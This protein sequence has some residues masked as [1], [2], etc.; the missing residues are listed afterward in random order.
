MVALTEIKGERLNDEQKAYL[1][2]LFAGMR[3]RGLSFEDVEPD[4]TKPVESTDTENLI[5]EE[6]V[7]RDLH[8]LDAYESLLEDAAAN[9]APCG[10]LEMAEGQ[11]IR[12]RAIKVSTYGGFKI[13]ASLGVGFGSLLKPV[14]EYFIREGLIGSR[15]ANQR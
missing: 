8:P 3:N 6:R 9:R 2:G 15:P 4:P 5:F 13:N 14:E 12:K 7:K 11:A 10:R 1:E